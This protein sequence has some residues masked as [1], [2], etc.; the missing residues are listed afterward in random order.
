VRAVRRM[1]P[2]V[3]HAQARA[4]AIAD[5]LGIDFALIHRKRRSRAPD[6]PEQMELLVGDVRGKV[7]PDLM[8][9]DPHP[10]ELRSPYWLTT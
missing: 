1:S 9:H 6:A 5:K 8:A 3:V 4:T 2:V 7:S 10:H